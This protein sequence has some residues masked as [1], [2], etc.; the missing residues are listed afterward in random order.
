MTDVEY[1]D[2]VLTF[3]SR[4]SALRIIGDT[5]RNIMDRTL[6]WIRLGLGSEGVSAKRLHGAVEFWSVVVWKQTCSVIPFTLHS[7]LF[8]PLI[9]SDMSG[10]SAFMY[11]SKDLRL[12]GV[13]ISVLSANA[14]MPSATFRLLSVPRLI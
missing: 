12:S 6:N 11:S 3:P 8:R 7:S 1:L 10:I 5:S 13:G 9:S 14:L 4:A 2:I